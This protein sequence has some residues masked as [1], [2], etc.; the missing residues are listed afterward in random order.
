MTKILEMK[1]IVKNF[2]S[3]KVLANTSLTVKDN[4]IVCLLGPSGSGKTTLFK[5]VAG[6]SKPDSGELLIE[7]GTR[8]SYVFQEP[9]LLPWKTIEENLKLI[10]QNYLDNKKAEEL[11]YNLLNLIGLE[12]I[13]NNYPAELSGGMKQRIE[14]IKAL[15]IKPD[16]LLMDEPFKSVDT[17]TRVNLQQMILRLQQKWNFSMFLITHDPEEAVLIADRIYV[18]SDKPGQIIKE[19]KIDKDQFNRSL[20]D[21]NIYAIRE[22]IISVFMKLVDE[23]CW[24]DICGNF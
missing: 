5:I 2:A 1:D 12:N 20:K 9:R 4:E 24:D 6:L 3:L 11:R 8:C 21:E 19:F 22:E 17:R 15:S 7:Q 14:I 18:L 16:L 10:Q 13:K 23:Y